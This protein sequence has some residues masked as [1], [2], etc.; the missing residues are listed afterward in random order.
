MTDRELLERAAEW[1][2]HVDHP[3]GCGHCYG[4][5]VFAEVAREMLA[6][7]NY[8]PSEWA[9]RA[10]VRWRDGK[11]FKLYQ[12]ALADGRDPKKAFAEKGWDL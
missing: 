5:V 8:N 6:E 4:L 11:Y 9:Q 2:R 12:E 1:D 3:D 7:G 10:D